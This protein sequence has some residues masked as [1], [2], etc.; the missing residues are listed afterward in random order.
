MKSAQIWSRLSLLAL[1]TS[2]CGCSHFPL[3]PGG[4]RCDPVWDRINYRKH[5]SDSLKA[6]GITL[7]K[8]KPSP[9]TDF[10]A[11]SLDDLANK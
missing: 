11:C 7:P 6:S 3:L 9:Q 10:G 1:L 2:L 5:Y 8:K 4:G